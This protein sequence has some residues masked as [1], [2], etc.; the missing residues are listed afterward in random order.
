MLSHI[1]SFHVSNSYTCDNCH[2]VCPTLGALKKHIYR[3]HRNK[4]IMPRDK[5]NLVPMDHLNLD[6]LPEPN[7]EVSK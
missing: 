6:F 7:F 5:K 1:E 3:N 4:N 2:H